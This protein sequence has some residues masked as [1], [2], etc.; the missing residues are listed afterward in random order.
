MAK[1][2][3]WDDLYK[4]KFK[5]TKSLLQA[6]HAFED[7]GKYC[8]YSEGDPLRED[9]WDLQEKRLLYGDY[10][11]IGPHGEKIYIPGYYYWYLNFCPILHLGKNQDADEEDYQTNIIVD[12]ESG[13]VSYKNYDLIKTDRVEGFPNF[14]DGDFWYYKYIDDA[15]RGGKFG[16]VLKV[17]GVGS[18]FKNASKPTRNYFLIPKSRSFLIADDKDFLLGDGVLQKAWDMM[19]FVDKHTDFAKRRQLT[20]TAMEKRASFKETIRGIEVESGFQSMIKGITTKND[21]G[22]VRGIRGKFIYLEE[23]G[24]DPNLLE[25]WQILRNS[26]QRGRKVFGFLLASGTGGQTGSDYAGLTELFSHPDG[27]NIY[28]I[29][30]VWDK[31]AS[32]RNTAFFW[33]AYINSESFMDSDGNSNIEEATAYEE[34]ER[35]RIAQSSTERHT[36]LRYKSENPFT[37]AEATLN[38]NKNIFPMEQLIE[39][40]ADVETDPYKL[41]YGRAGH[42]YRDGTGKVAF[43]QSVKD[44]PIESFPNNK[45]QGEEG[46]VVIYD[47]PDRVNGEVRPKLY[48]LSND[49]Y[50]HDKSHGPSLGATLVYKKVNADFKFRMNTISAAYV[51]RPATL[52]KY[53]DNLFMLAE[54]YNAKIAFENDKGLSIRDYAIRHRKLQ[55]L[56]V[57]FEFKYNT[58]IARPSIRRGYGMKMGAGK[59]DT[60][61]ITGEQYLADWLVESRGEDENGRVFQNLHTIYDRPLIQELIA[62]GDGNF[63]R[64]DAFLLLMY[65][66][67]ET[68]NVV[69]M[70]DNSTE[71]NNFFHRDRVAKFY[72]HSKWY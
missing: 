34:Q 46:C 21:P 29:P 11:P 61:R 57:E 2:V 50:Y 24:K 70:T 37:P 16:T 65:Y 39:H 6:A 56:Q 42:L 31:G 67:R 17:R 36:L 45:K 52:E 19:Y 53:L 26:V 72:Q 5:N 33:P 22:K 23:A 41:H 44:I 25:K 32:H 13:E 8:P 20:S 51:G 12:K 30:N 66:I 7:K 43:R 9:F 48:L 40:L 60:V 47:S 3:T 55:F 38:I 62:Y 69:P 28:G 35:A 63:D 59:D 58:Q 27:F 54:Y 14:W 49:P 64:V 18:S 71:E 10:F 68:I 4:I 1:V 15:E